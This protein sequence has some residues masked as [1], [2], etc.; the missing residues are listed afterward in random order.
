[1]KL[2]A[3]SHELKVRATNNAGDAQPMTSRCGIRPATCATS[4]KPFASRWREENDHDAF[5]FSSHSPSSPASAS[6]RLSAAPV[7]YK[8][9]EETAAFKPGPNLDVV[10]N[11]C[12]AC[13]SADYIKT[14]PRG[15]KFKKDFWQAEVDQDDQGLWRAD[16]R[17]RRRQDRR[18]SDRDLLSATSAARGPSEGARR[19]KPALGSGRWQSAAV[20]ESSHSAAREAEAPSGPTVLYNREGMAKPRGAAIR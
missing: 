10:Q 20:E 8:L 19:A 13:H 9:P 5:G 4:S 17:C 3:G 11:N 2:A 15:P 14:Q 12:T 7:S 16:R 6:P 18:L 1:M